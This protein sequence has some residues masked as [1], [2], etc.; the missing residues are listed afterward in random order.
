MF[1]DDIALDELDLSAIV[2]NTT[3]KAELTTGSDVFD[4]LDMDELNDLIQAE[5]ARPS[6]PPPREK[7]QKFI[8]YLVA[9]MTNEF[10][11]MDE[12][13]YTEKV[14]VLIQ[15]DENR[16]ITAKLRQEWEQTRVMVGDVVH[17]PYTTNLGE[18][19][20]DNQKNFIVV[21]PDRLISCTAVAD[22]YSCL[23]KSVLQLKVKGV[24]EYT[25]AL[26]HGNII[27]AVL[28]HAL[29]TG[30]FA[31][32]SVK[33]QMKNV[34][35]D[36]LEDLY[37]MDQDE[38]TALA[39]LEEYADHIHAFGTKY[40][41]QYPR[42]D[43]RV[44]K[45]MGMN[46]EAEMGCTSVSICKVLDIEEHLWSPTFGLKGMVDASVQ[47]R[48]SP[49]N[50]VLTVPFELK[51]GKVSRFITNRAQT[52]LYTLLMSDRY[53]VEI[54]AGILYYSKVNSLYLIPSSRN[55]LRSLIMAR[56]YLA[57]ACSSESL[58]PMLRNSHT[59][60]YCYI[61]DAC[62][63]YHK[64]VENGNGTTSGLYKLFDDKTDHMTESTCHFFKHWWELLDQEETDI[65]Y[66]RKD[67][68]SQPAEIREL[69]G[70]CLANMEL[71]L[72]TSRVDPQTEQW[73]YCFT[74]SPDQMEQRPLL[75]NLSAGDPVVVSSMQGHINLALGFVS[76]ISTTEIVLDLNEPLR[77]PPQ[78]GS[79]SFDA[80]NNQDFNS[81]IRFKADVHSYYSRMNIQYRIDKDEMSSGMA[82]LR[83][84]LVLLTA[85]SNDGERLRELIIDLEKP[86]YQAAT[87]HIP[88]TPHMNP[89]QRKALTRVVQADDYSLILGM[90]GTGKTTTTAEI[91]SY[92]VQNNK[93]V[94]V[95]AYTHTA[96][97][98]VLI[99]VREHGVD[100]LRLGNV[101]KVMPAMRDYVYQL[102]PIV[103]NREAT[104]AGLDKSLF[105]ILAE[106]RP[107]SISYLEYQ[108][109][110]NKDIM[111]VSNALIYDGKLK[112]G[113][114]QVASRT[115]QLPLLDAALRSVHEHSHCHNSHDCWL[116]S[117]L[118]PGRKNEGEAQ[119]I[120]QVAETLLKSGL[121]Q[122]DLAV[123]SVYRSQL[124]VISQLLKARKSIEIATIDKYQGRDKDCILISL[125]RNNNQG[126]AGDLLRDWR[127][128][129]VAI[130]RAKSKL[131]LFGSAST[132]RASALYSRLL[133]SFEQKGCI[134]KLPENAQILHKLP[135]PAAT[136]AAAA[137]DEN[138]QP[139]PLTPTP[140]EKKPPKSFLPTPAILKKNDILQDLYNNAL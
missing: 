130:T 95:A 50:K 140:K 41:N 105:A 28:Q 135:G 1:G 73:K 128:L 82:M 87:P 22:S 137:Q 80:L 14:L 17:I 9:S 109:R 138:E 76:S 89:D 56:N 124:R 21:H 75:C 122:D 27:H 88:P 10:Y 8:R 48:L 101:D 11:I 136:A 53:D 86:N 114:H 121:D 32:S 83:N 120:Y 118:D 91:I 45:N 84:N 132:L 78:L 59:C 29:Q 139:V 97:D 106:A 23:R 31:V 68:W 26:V 60:Q 63:L 127:R 96:L 42:P 18:I 57:I 111:D 79:S 37:A 74:R 43:A 98:N 119:L 102:P 90:P 51:T 117:V 131:V 70:R 5:K 110:M 12:T 92:L 66:I 94:L 115:L 19:I 107:E 58:P 125:V 81:F 36:S 34:I 54:G 129:N 103:R 3:K 67:I 25:E 62:T 108:Y 30:D 65:D 2:N 134:Y 77:N 52:L 93:T 99:K 100:V 20:I 7:R 104:D 4:D 64:A 123:I 24:S 40:V 33:Q 6:Q 35:A 44:S 46:P 71:H 72:A 85:K 47:V 126:N 38:E 69:S 49:T 16:A 112:C 133:D 113:N 55:D 61:N 13:R 15:E 39:I 116:A